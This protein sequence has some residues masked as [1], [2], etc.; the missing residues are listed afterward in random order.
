MSFM[1]ILA[2]A[3][4]V[5]F[6]CLALLGWWALGADGLRQAFHLDRGDDRFHRR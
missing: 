4:A 3:G 6:A 1:L 5:L 2:I